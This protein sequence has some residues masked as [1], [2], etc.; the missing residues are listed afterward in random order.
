MHDFRSTA[1]WPGKF[2]FTS[3]LLLSVVPAT[4]QEQPMVISYGVGGGWFEP[5]TNGQG[6]VFDVV[7]ATNLMCSAPANRQPR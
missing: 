4:A 3:F 5:A 7:P 1:G 2:L 6:I